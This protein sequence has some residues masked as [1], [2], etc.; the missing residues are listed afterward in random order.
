MRNSRNRVIIIY[1]CPNALKQRKCFDEGARE[2]AGGRW[3]P[4]PVYGECVRERE[5]YS[6]AGRAAP[7]SIDLR[8]AR[9]VDWCTGLVSLSLSHSHSHQ[10]T[11]RP[12]R[13][14]HCHWQSN[15]RCINAVRVPGR[16]HY[17]PCAHTY[18]LNVDINKFWMRFVEKG[19]IF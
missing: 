10:N 18:T 7:L 13:G 11:P 6:R 15:K 19:W 2:E 14:P 12:T 4:C 5:R 8:K 17:V 1:W 3:G 9:K 16:F